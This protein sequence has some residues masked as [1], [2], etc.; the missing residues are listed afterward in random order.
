[1]ESS[2]EGQRPTEA[3]RALLQALTVIQLGIDL[4][5]ASYGDAIPENE[6]MR[7]LLTVLQRA[8]EQIAGATRALTG[9]G[10]LAR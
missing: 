4:L 3:P 2:P 6:E 5:Q 8:T 10:R 9:A 1:M 7:A